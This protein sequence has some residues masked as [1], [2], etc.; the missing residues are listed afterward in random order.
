M[1]R[2]RP[3]LRKRSANFV[4]L[5]PVSFLARAATFF[6][7]RTAV[8]HGARHFTYAELYARTRQLAHALTKA[9]VRRG[10]TVAILAANTPAL[11]EAHYA[12]PMI[13][14]VLNPINIR[15]DPA[16][17]AFCLEHGEAKVLLADREF[18]KTVLPALDRLATKPLV[19]DIAD[20]ETPDAPGF[21]S[22]EYEAVLAAGDPDFAYPGP[23]D[24]WDSICLLYTSGTTGN[25]K[26]AVYSHRGAHLNALANA[27]TFKLDHDSR[28]LWTLPMFHCSGWTYTWAVTAAAG[29]HICLRRIEPKRIF[30]LI[31]EH[32]VTHMCGAPIVLNTLV[33]APA[34]A[35][36]PLPTRPKVMTGGAAPPSAVIRNMEAMGFEVLHAYGTTESY[37]PSTTCVHMREWD[38]GPEEHRFTNMARQGVPH[39]LIEE[40]TVASPEALKPVAR[41]G[42]VMGEIMLRG[43]TLMKG[44]L[45]NPD[46]TDEAFAGGLYHSGDLAVWHPDGYIEVK[47]RSKDIIISGGENISSLELEEVL[48]R[49]PQ[50]MEAAVVAKP[51]P[52]W[53][54]TPCAFVTL[55]PDAEPTTA[56]DIIAFCRANLA[57]FKIPKTF[58]FGP[59]PKTSTGKIQKF[60]LRERARE[61]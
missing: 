61:L 31:A 21:G 2:E 11:L 6:A 53:G 28:Y 59:L 16:T 56:E 41:N 50:I 26:G 43:N 47:D 37:G 33:H 7:D 8:I 14:A 54:E 32:G 52:K 1:D 51:D 35:K 4:P 38:S 25:P 17:I 5:T 60:V 58:V 39:A 3:E 57:G 29:T 48:Y 46:A 36:R 10:D 42:E 19:I 40:M 12:V 27:L 24:E 34:D 18:S 44:Y 13:G 49:H 30:D 15:L 20:A 23:E 22:A 9:G 55:K 45:K